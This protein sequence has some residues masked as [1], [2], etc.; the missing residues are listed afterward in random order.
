MTRVSVFDRLL[1]VGLLILVLAPFGAASPEPKRVLLLHSFGREVGPF[2]AFAAGFRL[3]LERQSRN[4]LAF[5]EVSLEPAGPGEPSEQSVISFL[6]SMFASR[7]PDLIVPVGGPASTFA[8]R[9]RSRLFPGTPMLMTAVDER[10]FEQ[11]NLAVTEAVAAVRHDV[12]MAIENIRRVLPQTRT[13]FVVLGNS[14]LEQFWR[15]D[16]GRE[17]QRFQNQLTFVWGNELSFAEMLKRCASLPP[18]STILYALLSVDAA[19][20][21]HTEADALAE[22]HAVANAPIF[23]VQSSQMGRGIVGGPLMSMDEL[24]RNATGAAVR[25]LNHQSPATVGIPSQLPGPNM[26]D[27]REL[28]RWHISENLLPAGSIV[29]FRE[30]TLWQRYKW[31]VLASVLICFA[32]ALLISSLLVNLIRRRRAEQSLR[33]SREALSD[34]SQ[35]LI[36]AQEKERSWLALILHD[37]INQRLAALRLQLSLFGKRLPTSM[38]DWQ[39][40][41]T[42]ANRQIAQLISDIQAVSHQLY[43]P[44][45]KHV[46]LV[47]T[48]EAL[49][50]EF[51]AAHNIDIEFH[52]DKVSK[53]IPE[54]VRLCLFRVLQEA[55]QNV[56]KHSGARRGEVLLIGWPDGIELTVRDEGNGFH[57][58]KGMTGGGLGL[59]SMEQR[60]KLV[61]GQVFIDSEPGC[62]TVIQVRVPLQ[63][64]QKAAHSLLM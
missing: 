53:D 5:Y 33:E 9:Y 43:S 63:S 41:L 34:M 48:A 27:W 15:E 32:E 23:G 20:F 61:N 14:P 22:L 47:Q 12:P 50:R 45:L 31:Y 17:F 10:H 38:D 55:L 59:P 2:D 62:G 52:S 13:V 30:P 29:Q 1:C 8:H 21:P 16:L 39:K 18:N 35:R 36:E 6:L 24:S 11:A 40:E 54:E 19:G 7:P 37:D 64:K 26:F 3:E 4:P 49:C 51:S 42:G 58:K 28:R 25:I 60:L 56:A 46:G 57:A 44:S